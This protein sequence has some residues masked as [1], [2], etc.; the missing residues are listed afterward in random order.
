MV[1][2]YLFSKVFLPQACAS[3]VDE[4]LKNYHNV[5]YY[6]YIGQILEVKHIVTALSV[7][8]VHLSIH[9]D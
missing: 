3:S 2:A 4:L 1:T 6:Y 7:G 5:N 8:L 9:A